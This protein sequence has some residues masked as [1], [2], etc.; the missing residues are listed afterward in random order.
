LG[1]GT[2]FVI[3]E[4]QKIPEWSTMVKYLFDQDRPSRQ[5]KVVLLSFASL[6]LQRKLAENL[7]GRYEITP[8]HHWNLD[9]CRRAF[10]WDIDDFL[11]FGGYSAAAELAKDVDRWQSYIR[12]SIKFH[13]RAGVDPRYSRAGEDEFLK[14][15]WERLS[16][17]QKESSHTVERVNSW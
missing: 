11:K 9:E 8:A 16:A 5:L 15:P 12:N 3:D 6:G 14:L 10:G 13:Y 4:I 1:P 2:L 7:A 17:E